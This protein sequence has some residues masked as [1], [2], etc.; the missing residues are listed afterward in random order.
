MRF[1][2]TAIVAAWMAGAA[3]AAGPDPARGD[4]ALPERLPPRPTGANVLVVYQSDDLDRDKNGTG[5][6][7]ESARYYAERRG[8]PAENL[9]GL[10]LNDEK[11]LKRNWDYRDFYERILT[12][13]A[14]KLEGKAA[15][16]KPF[17]LRIA[18]ILTLPNVPDRMD[19]H[20]AGDPKSRD[21]F[22]KT[23]RRSVD[24]YLIS[25]EQN[26]AAGVDEATGAPGK[27][28]AGPLGA[29]R[30]EV[31]LPLFGRFARLDRARSFLQLRG[32]HPETFNFYL[33]T[34]LG[35][36]ERSARDM[37]D[38]AL[39]A[40]RYLR[41][42]EAG[43]KPAWLP[44][45]WLDQKYGFA[46]D[47]VAAM[48]R[49]MLVVHGAGGSPFAAG[50]GLGRVWPLVIDNQLAEIGMASDG[51]QHRPTATATIAEGGVDA[52]G[53]TLAANPKAPAGRDVPAVLYFA[54]GRVVSNGRAQARIV[55]ADVGKNRLLLDSTAGFEA[56]QRIST[57]WGGAYPA[58]DCF[59]FY[60][61]YGLGQYEDVFRFPPGAMG[62]HVDS[63]CMN[64]ARGAIGRGI[65]GTFGVTVEPLS[66]GIPYGDLLL[67]ALGAGY[68]WA[69]AVYGSLLLGQRWAGVTFG[70]P[71]YAPFQ[72]QQL[73]DRTP[74]VLKPITIIRASGTDI[75][76]RAE[77][78]SGSADEAADVALFKLEYGATTDYGQTIDFY[79]WPQPEKS[80]GVA[81]RRFGYSRRIVKRLTGL[82]K[83]QTYHY[84]VTARDPAG[85]ET[86]S[87]DG[88]FRP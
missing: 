18:Y 36:D 48:S 33:V 52:K 88:T 6:S 62:I 21:F 77:L 51:A 56:G 86:R 24:Q 37:L 43:E 54:P 87:E 29:T 39:Y 34:R 80:K 57:V 58:D 26:L 41:L 65:A 49:T 47:Q 20:H 17:K 83:G 61:F 63:S 44:H 31:S 64:W 72:S 22:A 50:K 15:D 74:P 10:S 40:E 9:L 66:A 59:I 16:G 1:W 69:D 75:I 60:G 23:T 70:D 81:G 14:G 46:A 38:G 27:G 42:P 45:I 13:I 35:V 7:E 8:V 32:Q 55:G 76:I 4:A 82:E 84:R 53:V 78:A 68:P 19:T 3:W 30:P 12:P 11:G 5:E 25:I 28:A 85:L 2:T 67:L 79:D 71:I 73:V